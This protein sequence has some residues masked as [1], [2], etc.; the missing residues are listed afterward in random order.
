[1]R[2]IQGGSGA[3]LSAQ[4]KYGVPKWA[5]KIFG[6]RRVAISEFV[7]PHMQGEKLSKDGLRHDFAWHQ[8]LV[9]IEL[10]T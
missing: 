8:G 7:F 10:V 6:D 2:F 1:L 4:L 3:S 5:V 9:L